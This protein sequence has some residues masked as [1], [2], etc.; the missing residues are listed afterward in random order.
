MEQRTELAVAFWAQ[1]DDIRDS[2]F[3]NEDLE[4]LESLK[5][6]ERLEERLSRLASA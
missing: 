3:T 1:V 5:P 4:L 6:A 2:V